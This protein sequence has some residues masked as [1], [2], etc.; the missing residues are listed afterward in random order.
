APGLGFMDQTTLSGLWIKAYISET[1]F[2]LIFI[3]FFL[4]TFHPFILKSK[5]IYTV[6]VWCRVLAF[7]V[8]SQILRIFTFYST[9]LPG[10]NNHCQMPDRTSGASL[11]LPLT[12]KDKDSRNKDE[13]H[14]L[15]NGNSG[16]R[17]DRIIEADA[18]ATTGAATMIAG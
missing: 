15:L 14:K 5:R 18:T 3:S 8:A 4:W 16:D 6:L 10:P 11:L 12:S 7:S 13:N 2:T 1:L 9:Q 17:T